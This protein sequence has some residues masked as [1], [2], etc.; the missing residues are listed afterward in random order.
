MA[1]T[2][3]IADM[4]ESIVAPEST[5]A[6]L[7]DLRKQGGATCSDAAT[8]IEWMID[9]RSDYAR[10]LADERE[11]SARLTAELDETVGRLNRLDDHLRKLAD[12]AG[13]TGCDDHAPTDPFPAPPSAAKRR[14]RK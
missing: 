2:H 4:S 6:L 9:N 1:D 5:L 7:V 11:W 8:L 13:A 14:G 10:A 12:Y 3:E